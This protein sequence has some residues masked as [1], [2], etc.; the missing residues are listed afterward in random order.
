MES[1]SGDALWAS[2]SG[3][4]RDDFV[5]GSSRNVN[6]VSKDNSTLWCGLTSCKVRICGLP[7]LQC[8]ASTGGNQ[9]V[10]CPR[11]AAMLADVKTVPCRYS[12]LAGSDDV[13]NDEVSACG[14]QQCR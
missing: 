11:P 10:R 13:T 12:T 8:R 4:K 9:F 5:G 2:S 7:G 3:G 6:G 14:C 1:K